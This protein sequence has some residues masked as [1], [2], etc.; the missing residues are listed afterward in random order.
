MGVL[1][2]VIALAAAV[3]TAVQWPR[4]TTDPRPPQTPQAVV[5][6]FLRAVADADASRALEL[7]VI[8]SSRT[9][10]TDSALR[11]Q[12]STAPITDIRVMPA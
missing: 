6:S 8:P 9:F 4:D 3:L 1:L 10:L 5:H 2:V 11:A 12:R 7:M